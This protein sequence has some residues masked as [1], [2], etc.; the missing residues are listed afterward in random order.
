MTN[1]T[2]FPNRKVELEILQK[3]LSQ[4]PRQVDVQQWKNDFPEFDKEIHYLHEHELIECKFFQT[5]SDM[6]PKPI[7]AK[8]SHKG[9]DFL[10]DD[11]GLSAI[12]GVVT[13]KLHN[14]TIKYLIESKILSST[15]LN[16]PEKQKYI[17][18]LRSLPADATKHVV[19][20]LAEKGLENFPTVLTW[21]S[22]LANQN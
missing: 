8:I 13:I 5:L 1:E 7:T 2:P 22:N 12:L 21:I 18:Q 17:A 6:F 15:E 3:L 10:T 19:L 16:Q 4:Y 20:K 9:V 11:G 14:D